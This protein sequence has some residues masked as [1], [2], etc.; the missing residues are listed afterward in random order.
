MLGL[1]IKLFCFILLK[2][3]LSIVGNGVALVAGSSRNIRCTWDS[4]DMVTLGW[5]LQGLESIPLVVSST[6]K[7]VALYI[8]PSATGLDGTT[9]ICRATDGQGDVYEKS[10]TVYVKGKA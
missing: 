5:F 3:K 7:T 9:F 6:S 4:N 2:G 1:D 8:D 10:T